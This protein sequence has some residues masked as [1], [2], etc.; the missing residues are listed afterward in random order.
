MTAHWAPE[1]GK[2]SRP[3]SSLRRCR[4]APYMNKS[5]QI[6]HRESMHLHELHALLKRHIAPEFNVRI[7]PIYSNSLTGMLGRLFNDL[8]TSWRHVAG[9]LEISRD[10]FE[11]SVKSISPASP[12]MPQTL[13]VK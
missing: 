10:P 1:F 2:S 6:G 3:S 5:Y 9:Q 12:C 7:P 8:L 13:E 11:Y 4:I